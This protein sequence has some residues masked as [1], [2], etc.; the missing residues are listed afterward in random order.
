MNNNLF[1]LGQ[2]HKFLVF[3]FLSVVEFSN[4]RKQQM[5][6]KKISRVNIDKVNIK[7]EYILTVT[8][9]VSLCP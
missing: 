5:F 7:V 6:H 9:D 4:Q 2:F 3:F 8:H 1:W